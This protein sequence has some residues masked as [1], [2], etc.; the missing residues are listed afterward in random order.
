MSMLLEWFGYTH[1]V[2]P[3]VDRLRLRAAK[4]DLLVCLD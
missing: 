1:T 4:G 2:P 3:G